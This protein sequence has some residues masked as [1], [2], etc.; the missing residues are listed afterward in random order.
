MKGGREESRRMEEGTRER[1]IE[2][3]KDNQRDLL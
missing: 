2:R 1:Q 3:R